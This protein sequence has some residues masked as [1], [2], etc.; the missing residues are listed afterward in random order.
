MIDI[1]LFVLF[2]VSRP[3]SICSGTKISTRRNGSHVERA[4][5]SIHRIQPLSNMRSH[6]VTLGHINA[7]SAIRILS[8]IRIWNFIWINTPEKN[9]SNV[10]TAR[11]HVSFQ[12]Q[13]SHWIYSNFELSFTSSRQLRQ[14]IFASKAPPCR[15]NEQEDDHEKRWQGET[16][17][18][19][20]KLSRHKLSCHK[21]YKWCA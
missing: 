16:L 15:W 2:A 20:C 8:A 4:A 11:E 6:T 17:G 12:N 10:H 7:V 5:A 18:H 14:R 9:H 19:C 3:K 21:I 1:V 13:C